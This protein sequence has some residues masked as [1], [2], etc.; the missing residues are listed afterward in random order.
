MRL[1]RYIT[2]FLLVCAF[3]GHGKEIIVDSAFTSAD[4]Y[5]ALLDSLPPQHSDFEIRLQLK[6][7]SSRNTQLY[8]SIINPT[9][10]KIEILEDSASSVLGD[11][12]SFTR[13]TFK[14]INHVYPVV[15]PANSTK[16]IVIK[17]VKQWQAANFRV[18]IATE[19]SFIKT[20]NHDNFFLGIFYGLL[21]MYMLLLLCFYFFSKSNFF[22]L[23]LA[24]NIF[25]VLIYL[26]FTGTGYQFIWFYSPFIQKNITVFAVIGYL[27]AHISFVRTF[28][29][30]QFRS[31]FTSLILKMFL[32]VLMIFGILFLLQI[33]NRSYGILQ[34]VSFYM[35]VNSLF[36]LYGITVIGLCVNNYVES[37]RREIMWVMIGMLFHIANW[38]I[39]INNEFGMVKGLNYAD[40]VQLFSSNIFVP[41][42]N[43]FIT[44]L[45]IL[46]VTVFISINY[47]IL[48]RQNNLS[49]KRLEFLQ[50]RNI[51]TFVLGQ[52]AE[53]DR[54]SREI[55]TVISNDIIHLKSSLLSFH[56]SRQDMKIPVV[57]DEIEKTLEDVQHITTNYVAPDMQQMLLT[58]LI[59]T[60]TDK[61][62]SE[63]DVQYDF[64]KIPEHLKLSAV[65]NVN[66]YRV[67]QEISNNILKHAK[68]KNVLI[69]AIRD[70]KTLQIKISDD[71]IGF[72]ES[73]SEEN[74][75][76]GLLNIESRITSLNGNFYVL[77]DEKKGSTVHLI[78]NLKDIV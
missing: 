42:V 64:V 35:L 15:L 67:L 38:I 17:I 54:I 24:I 52:E 41:Q 21:F 16:E 62:Y 13:R 36:L 56:Q 25:T 40:T 34:N 51:N 22:L 14:H 28:F 53:R 6:N 58:Q 69:T 75:G 32:Y 63:V 7:I 23:Y 8:L 12:I 9:I 61:L 27:T 60:A 77:S 11:K 50:K 1:K 18:H 43:F 65:A 76:I 74:K 30:V 26:E 37:R 5:N 73:I 66:L 44:M 78:M 72:T 48:I 29:A 70:N 46:I 47:H 49:T 71:G 59:T 45:E 3:T 19:N 33:F 68:A 10:D 55:G 31:N 20:T 57:L 4:I 39:F 2:L